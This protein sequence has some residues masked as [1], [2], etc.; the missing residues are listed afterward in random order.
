[1]PA[2]MSNNGARVIVL[3]LYDAGSIEITRGPKTRRCTA[4]ARSAVR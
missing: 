1:M 3:P 2:T 4:A